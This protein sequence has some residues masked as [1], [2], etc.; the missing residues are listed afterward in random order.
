[1]RYIL[2]CLCFIGAILASG[3]TL[4]LLRV[5][6][7]DRHLPNNHPDYAHVWGKKRLVYGVA[8][9]FMALTTIMLWEAI[10]LLR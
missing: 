6:W 1:M 9:M 8:A 10:Q 7:K 3:P 2:A 5:A 4:L